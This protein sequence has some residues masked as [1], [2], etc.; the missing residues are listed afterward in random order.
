[1]TW[2][3]GAYRVENGKPDLAGEITTSIPIAELILDHVERHPADLKA[4]RMRIGPPDL[5]AQ[6]DPQAARRAE[7]VSARPAVAFVLERAV[8]PTAVA[9]L[10][11]EGPDGP[12]PVW[13]AIHGLLLLGVLRRADTVSAAAARAASEAAGIASR[14]EIEGWI[15]K[16]REG[17]LYDVLGV[18]PEADIGK[19][20]AAYYRHARRLHPDRIRSGPDADLLGAVETFFTRVTEAYNTLQDPEARRE[21]D[22]FLRQAAARKTDTVQDTAHLARQNFLRGRA[23]LEKR[24][25]TEALTFFENAVRLDDGQA[26]YH[27]ELG[28]LLAQNVRRRDDAEAAARRAIEIDPSDPSNYVALAEVLRRAQRSEEAIRTLRE[29]LRWDPDH[30]GA[31]EALRAL[32]G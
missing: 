23:A 1:M 8:E 31:R 28:L 27:R 25:L 6:V 4:V 19:I 24:R 17:T 32:D 11:T 26:D 12:E 15:A 10:A 18:D 20:R 29:A 14:D 7:A 16:G 5:R 2:K 13:R 9:D 3:R 21:Y 22:R 30:A